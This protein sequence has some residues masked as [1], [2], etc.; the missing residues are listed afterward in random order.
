[1]DKKKGLP[2]CSLGRSLW[3]ASVFHLGTIAFGSCIL[4]IVRTIRVMLEWVEKK[5]KKFNNDLTK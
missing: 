1:M 5:L 3:N 4:A 2:A